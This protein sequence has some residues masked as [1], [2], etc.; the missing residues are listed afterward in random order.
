[1][2]G[3]KAGDRVLFDS[4]NIEVSV[5]S[6]N[7]VSYNGKEYKLTTFCKEFLPEEKRIK[8]NA[9]QGPNYFSYQGK[10]LTKIRKEK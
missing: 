3:L 4:L 10:T 9:Y 6:D 2:I 7:T 5:A 8:S 1:M